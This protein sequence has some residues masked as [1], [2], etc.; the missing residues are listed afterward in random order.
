MAANM[1]LKTFNRGAMRSGPAA[2][3]SALRVQA[4]QVTM[5][6]PSGCRKFEQS[7]DK[8]LLEGALAAGIEV[9]NLCGT[10]TCGACA[11][12]LV[13]GDVERSDFLL[14]DQQK[15]A[16]FLLLC[17]TTVTSDVEVISHQETELHTVPY[18]I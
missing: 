14:D 15:E 10:G 13:S 7:A 4:F 3:T 16:G 5:Q 8:N 9:P 17:T 1:S 18:G 11:S 2:R 6:T 12:R